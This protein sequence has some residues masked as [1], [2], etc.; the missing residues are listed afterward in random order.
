MS[1]GSIVRHPPAALLEVDTSAFP[2]AQKLRSLANKT[3]RHAEVTIWNPPRASIQ[4][5]AVGR[6]RS[7]NRKGK[8]EGGRHTRQECRS[9]PEKIRRSSH[10]R[11]RSRGG[12]SASTK[13]EKCPVAECLADLSARDAY[14]CH[15]PEVLRTEVC[16]EFIISEGWQL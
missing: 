8:M 11:G 3:L 5:G 14:G 12:P 13:P 6:E 7:T 2:L 15:I 10:A 9:C 4:G 1:A 16:C